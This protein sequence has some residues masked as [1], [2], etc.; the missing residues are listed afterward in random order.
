[1][2]RF[3]VI[4]LLVFSPFSVIA[5]EVRY[6]TDQ[7]EITMRSGKGTQHKI[8]KMLRSG[9]PL[10]LIESDDKGYALVANKGGKEGWILSRY[11]TTQPATTDQLRETEKK[12]AILT[13]N[14]NRLEQQ[15][16]QLKQ[17]NTTLQKNEHILSQE[18]KT[19]TKE[20]NQVKDVASNELI[21]N[22]DNKT[23]KSELLTLRR[24]VQSLQQENATL[25]DK[26]DRQWFL[27]GGSIWVVGM[28]LGLILPNLRFRKKRNSWS[29]L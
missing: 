26:S 11:L 16:S 8:I 6:V 2:N 15:L 5:N 3:Y 17:E 22:E 10:T 4:F 19:L 25:H 9:T 12:R 21:I 13:R 28:L 23:L 1:M 20:L 27:T 14:V 24:D 7:L 18:K 29:T